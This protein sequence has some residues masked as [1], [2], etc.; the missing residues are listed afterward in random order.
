MQIEYDPGGIETGNASIIYHSISDAQSAVTIF[1]KAT[2][3]GHKI[4][5]LHA[6]DPYRSIGTDPYM[7]LSPPHLLGKEPRTPTDPYRSVGTDPYMSI[8]R[9]HSVSKEPRPPSTSGST[10]YPLFHKE[11]SFKHGSREARYSKIGHKT[12]LSSE[13]PHRTSPGQIISI[14]ST[15][16]SSAPFHSAKAAEFDAS[17]DYEDHEDFEDQYGSDDW[18]EVW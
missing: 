14:P 13:L 10:R 6:T 8:S 5:V 17:Y 3:H 2:L 15:L 12:R 18:E 7:S 9:P 16:Q 4:R 11:S 1:H